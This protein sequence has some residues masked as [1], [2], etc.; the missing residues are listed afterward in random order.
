M[1]YRRRQRRWK[2]TRTTS[3]A[4]TV[5]HLR[6]GEREEGHG[7]VRCGSLCGEVQVGDRWEGMECDDNLAGGYVKRRVAVQRPW[8]VSFHG[9]CDFLRRG[10][11]GLVESERDHRG[12]GISAA[13]VPRRR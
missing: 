11:G 2:K 7:A 5:E 3:T 4:R 9:A 13:R 1:D 10:R 6:N 8:L 12:M